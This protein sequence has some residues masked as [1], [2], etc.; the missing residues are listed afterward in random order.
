[1]VSPS[2]THL[3]HSAKTNVAG[4][5]ELR[6]IAMESPTPSLKVSAF[7]PEPMPLI[8]ICETSPPLTTIVLEVWRTVYGCHFAG[9]RSLIPRCSSDLSRSMATV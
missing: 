3:S 8:R 7:D 1:M 4:G 6:V 9:C 5:E 2:F